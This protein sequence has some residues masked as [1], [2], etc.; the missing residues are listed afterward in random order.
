MKQ[1]Q[2]QVKMLENESDSDSDKSS[3][4]L[5]ENERKLLRKNK[6]WTRRNIIEY[7][8]CYGCVILLSYYNI[9][10]F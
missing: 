7:L 1:D 3:V 4:V 10:Y 2:E 5:D 8:T 6:I 9:F